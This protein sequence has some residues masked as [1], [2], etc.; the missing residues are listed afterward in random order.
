MAPMPFMGLVAFMAFITFMVFVALWPF[1]ALI[2]FMAA[3]AFMAF[4]VLLDFMAFMPMVLV[5]AAGLDR[6]DI[7]FWAEGVGGW[8]FSWTLGCSMQDVYCTMAM[9]S[10]Y[11]LP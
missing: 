5:A 6:T 1:M 4:M 7:G 11:E 10:H 2:S 8:A 3:M 9:K